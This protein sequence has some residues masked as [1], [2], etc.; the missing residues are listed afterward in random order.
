[1]THHIPHR[2]LHTR[3]RGV[4]LVIAHLVHDPVE[5]A[6]R[7]LMS[8]KSSTMIGACIPRRAMSTPEATNLIL[9]ARAPCTAYK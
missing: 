9:V 5:L 1:M 8:T 4:P 6:H 3:S 7:A 2:P